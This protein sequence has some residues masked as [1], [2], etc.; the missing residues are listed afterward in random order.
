VGSTPLISE[1]R[2]YTH[3]PMAAKNA[4]PMMHYLR[5]LPRRPVPRVFALHLGG[6]EGSPRNDL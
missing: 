5:V 2:H 3:T 4:C 1:I 6:D